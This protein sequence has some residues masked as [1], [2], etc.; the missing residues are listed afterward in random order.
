MSGYWMERYDSA[1]TPSGRHLARPET[2]AT[3]PDAHA[4]VVAALHETNLT[5]RELINVSAELNQAR[6]QLLDSL[7]AGR[8]TSQMAWVLQTVLIRLSA[9]IRTL[10]GERDNYLRQAAIRGAELEESVRQLAR[11][12]QERGR[13]EVQL[14]QAR[15]ERRR[16]A[17]L[18]EAAQSRIRVLE[19]RLDGLGISSKLFGEA[20]DSLPEIWTPTPDDLLLDTRVVLD[21]MQQLLDEQDQQ[22]K[23]LGA[24]LV[25]AV[26]DGTALM[27]VL[28]VEG[29]EPLTKVAVDELREALRCEVVIARD[30]LEGIAR[31]SEGN[32]DVVIVE[33]LFRASTEEFDRRRGL[34]AVRLQDPTLHL[35]GLAVLHAI[36][37]HPNGPRPVFWTSGEP[38]RHLHMLFAYEELGTRVFCSKEALGQLV[39]AVRHAQASAEYIDPQLR[40][41]IPKAH[42]R[43]LRET[44]L[45][46]H[47]KLSIWRSLA[48]GQYQHTVIARLLGVRAT[49]VRASISE[50]RSQLLQLDPGR[51]AD[52]S[53]TSELIGYATANW[54][55]FLDDTVRQMFP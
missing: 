5:Q 51:V 41:Y 9:L 8:R 22:L 23:E 36:H 20:G 17:V 3:R 47:T 33:M 13:A 18:A 16:A 38:N 37:S 12:N 52:N 32:Y 39:E 35:S 14:E 21:R 46:Q 55:F 43:K 25:E 7:Q 24:T 26:V 15:N 19:A 31:L 10:S 6:Q 30:P 28:I 53:P 49:T 2:A 34:N 40:S 48:L 44:I 42:G 27:Q 11:A 1:V 54:E 45:S 4:R 50:M 29:Q